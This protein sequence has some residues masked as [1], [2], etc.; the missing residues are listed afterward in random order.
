MTTSAQVR[1]LVANQLAILLPAGTKV[2]SPRDWSSSITDYPCVFVNTDAEDRDGLGPN[3]A[4][5]FESIATIKVSARVQAPAQANDGGAVVAM[6]ALELLKQQIDAALINNP[7]FFQVIEEIPFVRSKFNVDSEAAQHMG[8]V[9]IEYGMKFYEGPENFFQVPVV[10]L[11]ELTVDV[12]L[13]NIFDPT[14]TY[15]NPPFPAAVEP[16]PRTSGPDGRAE[17]GLDI[18]LPQ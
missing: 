13:T 14:G 16:A 5:E 3:T 17:G 2:Y 10:P 6:L 4:Q 7:A 9:V 8:E 18:T 15:P 12:D 1:V 11:T